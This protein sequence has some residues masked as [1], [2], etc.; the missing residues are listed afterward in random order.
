MIGFVN[1]I[2]KA[3]KVTSKGYIEHTMPCQAF[4]NEGFTFYFSVV[5]A[6]SV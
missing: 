1:T 2:V 3:L 6:N 5:D 4:P